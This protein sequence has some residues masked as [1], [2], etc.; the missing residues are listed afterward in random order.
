MVS[1]ADDGEMNPRIGVT[2]TTNSDSQNTTTNGTIVVGNMEEGNVLGLIM[3]SMIMTIPQ[4]A[5][6]SV[7]VVLSAITMLIMIDINRK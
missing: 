3:I 1:Y 4:I 6:K 7:T 5:G 2:T